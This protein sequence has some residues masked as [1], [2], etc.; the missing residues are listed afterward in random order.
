MSKATLLK[1]FQ[2]KR[3]ASATHN[4]YA[5]RVKD[6]NG[7]LHEYSN[8]DGEFRAVRKL[9]NLLQTNNY[10]DAIVICTRWY[11]EKDLGPARFERIEEAAKQALD[12]L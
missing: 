10:E 4:I 11:G 2:D 7:K 6:S 5:Y 8:D 1:V 9:L 12:K 3:V